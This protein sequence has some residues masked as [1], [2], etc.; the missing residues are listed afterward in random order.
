MPEN[1]TIIKVFVASPGDVTYERGRLAAVIEEINRTVGQ[2]EGYRLELRRWETDSYPAMGRP[3]GIINRQIGP[4]DIFIGIMWRRFGTPTGVAESGTEEEFKLAFDRWSDEQLPHIMF[5]FNEAPFAPN[6][7]TEIEQ[8]GKVLQFRQEVQ[9][10][11]LIG[12]YPNKD[13]FEN[14]VRP[15][16]LNVI[17]EMLK[18]NPPAK[19]A[20]VER[21]TSDRAV[22]SVAPRAA[23]SGMSVPA[24]Y[25]DIPMPK[26]KK[27]FTDLEKKR[28]LRSALDLIKNYFTEGLVQL[29]QTNGDIET[30]MEELQGGAFICEAFVGGTSRSQCHIWIGGIISASIAYRSGFFL[31]RYATNSMNDWATLEEGETGLCLTIGGGMFTAASGTLRCIAPEKVAEHFWKQFILP[32]QR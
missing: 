17:A 24:L 31:D 15:H 28:F 4:Y 30:E 19:Y 2:R 7:Q 12:T 8:A 22:E 18:E 11:G 20:S 16:L 6:N 14:V 3:Q 9:K 23:N 10:K 25:G 13:S 21:M 29:R 26:V 27:T 5:Y 1:V 32:L